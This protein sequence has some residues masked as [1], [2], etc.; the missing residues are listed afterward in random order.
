MKERKK[1]RETI[2]SN[3]DTTSSRYYRNAYRYVVMRENVHSKS[4]NTSK[5]GTDKGWAR[6]VIQARGQERAAILW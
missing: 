1:K 3:I 6:V 4:R 2:A 5:F